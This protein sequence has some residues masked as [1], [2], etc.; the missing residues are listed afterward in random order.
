MKTIFLVLA[1]MTFGSVTYAEDTIQVR[2]TIKNHRFEP[3]EIK[4]PANKPI[5]LT[6]KNADSTPEEFES[7]MMRLE[8]VIVGGGEATLQIRALSPGRYRFYGDYSES[9]AEGFLVVE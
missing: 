3:A 8:K 9:T 6:V 4:V 7:K 2:T 1:L 5:S